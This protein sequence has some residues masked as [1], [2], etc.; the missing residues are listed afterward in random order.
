[1]NGKIEVKFLT[2]TVET[3]L[4]GKVWTPQLSNF[5]FEKGMVACMCGNSA[6]ALRRGRLELPLKKVTELRKRLFQSEA[7]CEAID[8]K[9]SLLVY[10]HANKTL[11]WDQAPQWGKKGKKK[12]ASDSL[13]RWNVTQILLPH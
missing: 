13:G 5:V 4:T 9:K 6:S 10:S 2:G 12:S 7:E 11:A 8:M 3:E 1:M